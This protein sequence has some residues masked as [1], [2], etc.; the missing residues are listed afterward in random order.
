V[1]VIGITGEIGAGKSTVA[2]LLAEAGAAV[3]DADRVGHEVLDRPEVR[4]EL[5]QTFGKGVCG[6]DGAIDRGALAESVFANAAQRRRL[7]AIV[8]PRMRREFA[9]RIAHWRRAGTA[10][11]VLDAAILFEAGWEA[12]CDAT[13]FVTAPREQ[14][15]ARVRTARRWSAADLGLREDAQLPPDQKRRRADVVI[16]NDGTMDNCRRQ[17]ES[18]RRRWND[19]PV[20]PPSGVQE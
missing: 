19:A 12:L 16:V 8:H 18:W 3:I 5:V 17:L 15:E 14:R 1:K 11:V 6:A 4:E 20:A 13:I 2:A 10:L 9:A 7:E